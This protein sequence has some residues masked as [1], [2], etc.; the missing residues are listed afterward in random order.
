MSEFL[1][2][3]GEARSTTIAGP[4]GQIE[5]HLA[6]PKADVARPG[7]ALVC[8]PHPLMGGAL[9]NKVTYTLASS[10]LKAGLHALRFNFRG[11][12]KSEGAHDGGRAE[13][14]DVVFLGEWLRAQLPP[15]P[16]ALMGFSFGAW[17]SVNAAARL[18]PAMQ[19]SIAPPFAKYFDSLPKPQRPP[20]PWLVVHGTADDVVDL[21]ETKLALAGY[22]PPPQL[23]TVADAGHFF[24]GRLTDL[25]DIVQPFIEHP[26]GDTATGG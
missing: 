19:V 18:K 6:A 22:E 7:F 13:T 21:D 9:S 8:H 14:D 17:V 20:C 16:L 11:V 10:A 24:H 12:G 5:I 3:P 2:A 23:V 15:G 4:A 1:P 25:G 26:L